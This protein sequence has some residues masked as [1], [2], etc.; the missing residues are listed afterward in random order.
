MMEQYARAKKEAP[1][2]LLFFRM[3]DFYELFHQ[4]AVTVSR[5]LGLTLT[6]RSKGEGA[7]PMAGVP[8]RTIEG[9]LIRLVRMGHKV[10]ICEQLEDPRQ[11][12]GIVD[13][14]IVR[15]VTPGTMTEEIALNARD[16]H[17]LAALWTEGERGALAWVDLSTGRMFAC[18]FHSRDSIDQIV[19][20]A[21]A[22]L[23]VRSG[24]A[25]EVPSLGD[26]VVEQLG[27]AL[28]EREAWRFDRSI[29]ERALQRH[30][31]VR[32][33]SGF[34]VEAGSA[35]VPA[36]GALLEYV[37]ETQRAECRHIRRIERIES[38]HHL[39]LDRATRSCLELV[40]T[41]RDG[42]R[43]GTVLESIDATMTAMG[44][45]MLREWLLSPLLDVAAIRHRQE[46]VANL[47]QV[48]L[49]RDG[50]REL[51]DGILDMERIGGRIAAGRCNARDLVGLANSMRIVPAVKDR[52]QALEAPI[53]RELASSIDP[54]IDL[55]ERI[56]RTLVPEPQLALREGGLVRAGVSTELDELRSIANDGKSWMARFQAE[57]IEKCG[58][59][60]LRLGFN[61][62]F[63]YF[64]EVPRGQVAR[65]PERYVRKQTI[66]TAER[67]VTPELKE[68]E[69]K[70]LNS[71]Q[72][73]R[74]HEYRI[75]CE[76]R[77]AIASSIGRVLDTSCALA[78]LDA[79]TGLAE[80]ASVHRYVRPWVDEGDAI[81]IVEGR[82]PV[83]ERSSA[84]EHF[85]PNGTAMDLDRNRL[86]IL[87]GPNMAGKSTYIRQVALIV[88]LAQI[89][90]F[91][92]AD[93]ARIGVV[94]RIFTRVGS[95]DDIS[96]GESTFMVEMVEIANILNNAT[97]R[98][99][100]ILDEVGRGTSTFDGL[101]LAW[102]IAEHL[103]EGVGARTLFATHY[104]QLTDLAARYPGVVN[105]NVAV[106]EWGDEIVFLHKIVDGGTDRSYGIHVA[107]LAGVPLDVLGRARSI[108]SDLERAEEGLSRRI[109]SH[110]P[111][112][113]SGSTPPQGLYAVP[114][115]IEAELETLDPDALTPIQA[116]LKLRALKQQLQRG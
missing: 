62:V 50:L 99:L 35:I 78:R 51:L 3:G 95:G 83:I 70:V 19:R 22:E 102:A 97:R 90:S 8:V 16:P 73:A 69:T 63:G 58:I 30:F 18:E 105:K 45:R 104:H 15:I 52:L 32:S 27:I 103:H 81:E 112:G 13:R 5:V 79:L 28:T 77:D 6:S 85:V 111:P 88:L 68:Y 60:N 72:L 71:E 38:S 29:T 2:A 48:P 64:I 10:A 87:T 21:P 101:A 94:D 37:S 61:S 86:V 116:L 49:A 54:L 75:F 66:K 36:S 40:S 17:F 11:A 98:S 4:D 44:S 26:Q 20:L 65:V 96:R 59:P 89:G 115:P 23:L 25:E 74:D 93:E 91:V 14:G 114:S 46:G 67:Y 1:D 82:H 43:E 57:E 47:V 56:D 9:Y 109:L 41:Q 34:G 106:R 100:V 76:L 33:L 55:T 107:R 113:T 92:P 7:I 110:A 12:K 108:L 80:L 84:C 42:R 31:Q 39:V 24:L 53:L